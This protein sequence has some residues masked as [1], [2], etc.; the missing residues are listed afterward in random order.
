MNWFTQTFASSIGKKWL[1]AITGLGFC[2]FLTTHLAGNLFIYGGRDAF[3]SYADHLHS[4]G[5]L[6]TLFELGL[7]TFAVLHVG[8]G[9]I[10]FYQNF[11]SRP[12]RYVVNNSG[13]GRTIGSRTMPYTGLLILVFVIFHLLNFTFTDKTGTTIFEIVSR[14]F[15]NPVNVLLYVLAMAV[16]AIH[17]SHGFW[18]AFQT[19]GANHPKYMP[20]IRGA[21]IVFSLVV[22]LGFGLL[23]IYLLSIA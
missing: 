21:G 3:N 19:L 5:P 15:A 22:G 14:T 11:R 7:L 2:G 1:M 8:S 4:L 16:A 17:V 20:F 18:S 10:L 6:V 9:L 23:P 13:G 12:N